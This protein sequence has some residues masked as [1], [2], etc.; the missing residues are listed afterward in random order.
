M[1]DAA[2][3]VAAAGSTLARFSVEPAAPVAG[4]LLRLDGSISLPASGR[5]IVAYEWTVLDDPGVLA[6][7]AAAATG[8]RLELATVAGGVLLVNLTVT[9]DAGQRASIRQQVLV[10][11]A[12]PVASGGSGGGASSLAW[13]ALLGLAVWVLLW[14][15]PP[16]GV[17]HDRPWAP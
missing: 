1:L 16:T 8:S 6:A 11:A 5:G 17:R 7:P 4:D 10:T 2:A 15:R 13:V 14:V 9:D 12:A 3:A